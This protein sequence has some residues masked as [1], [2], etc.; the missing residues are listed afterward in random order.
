MFQDDIYPHCASL[1]PALSADEWAAG[2]NADPCTMNLDPEQR[3]EED[4][5]DEAVQ[6][7]KRSPCCEMV[8]S[9]NALLKKLN[10]ELK[11]APAKLD[12]LV[13]DGDKAEKEELKKKVEDIHGAHCGS[14]LVLF[15]NV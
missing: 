13:T 9:E 12:L 8:A 14:L 3:K 11:E 5:G 4:G 10:K 6:F 2:S 15:T 7:I 1:K